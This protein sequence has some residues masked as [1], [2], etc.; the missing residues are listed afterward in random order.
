MSRSMSVYITHAL[1]SLP[2]LRY[3]VPLSLPTVVHSS[4]VNPS[5]YSSFLPSIHLNLL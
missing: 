5:V 1:L 4:S 3:E 2:S